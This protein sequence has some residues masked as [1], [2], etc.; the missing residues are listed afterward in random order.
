MPWI[1]SM[2]LI[3]H[4]QKQDQASRENIQVTFQIFGK[5]KM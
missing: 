2:Q 5:K 4:L 3:G 1:E